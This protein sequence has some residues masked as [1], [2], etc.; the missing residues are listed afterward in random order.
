MKSQE[1]RKLSKRKSKNII[2]KRK[3]DLIER[4]QKLVKEGDTFVENNIESFIKYLDDRAVSIALNGNL[5]TI[6]TRQVWL[7]NPTLNYANISDSLDKW[8]YFFTAK[9]NPK[10]IKWCNQNGIFLTVKEKW[11]Y[12]TK[13]QIDNEY[14]IWT[15]KIDLRKH[16]WIYRQCRLFLSGDKYYKFK[17]KRVKSK[18]KAIE[19]QVQK[20]L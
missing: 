1:L 20:S 12:N 11:E 4:F 8:E 6:Y 18:Y 3:N 16:S 17:M 5:S 9:N 2:E 19:K 10:L 7:P 14:W 13:Q 15:F